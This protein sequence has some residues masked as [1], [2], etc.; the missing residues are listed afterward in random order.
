MNIA[1]FRFR[2][3]DDKGF[4]GPCV[5][6]MLEEGRICERLVVRVSGDGKVSG[7]WKGGS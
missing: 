6:S 3:H 4:D 5:W 1:D 7:I 2:I